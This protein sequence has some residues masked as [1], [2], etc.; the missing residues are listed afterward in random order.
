MRDITN[1]HNYK[2]KKM[3]HPTSSHLMQASHYYKQAIEFLKFDFFPY[4]FFS[5]G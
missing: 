3:T 1:C 4:F 2:I 5:I